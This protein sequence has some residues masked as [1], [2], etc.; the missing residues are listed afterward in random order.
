MQAVYGY[1]QADHSTSVR[2][3][4]D[5]CHWFWPGILFIKYKLHHNVV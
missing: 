4:F 3:N 2:Q 5:K 1:A